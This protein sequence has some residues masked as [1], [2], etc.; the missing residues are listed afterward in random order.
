MTGVLIKGGNLDIET[1]S[2]R[3][4]L[5]KNVYVISKTEI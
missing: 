1:H 5:Y 2:Q 4:K 3:G